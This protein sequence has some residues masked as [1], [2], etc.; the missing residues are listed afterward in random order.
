MLIFIVGCKFEYCFLLLLLTK[1]FIS[2]FKKFKAKDDYDNEDDEKDEDYDNDDDDDIVLMDIGNKTES[3][4]KHANNITDELDLNH[5]E[6]NNVIKSN[7]ESYDTDLGNQDH[8]RYTLNSNV[9]RMK[10]ARQKVA[11]EPFP[12]DVV[13]DRNKIDTIALARVMI[14]ELGRYKIPRSAFADHILHCSQ[15]TLTRALKDPRPWRE[16]T[17]ANFDSTKALYVQIKKWLQKPLIERR[18]EY[19]A[20]K[21]LLLENGSESNDITSA[22]KRS[23][24]SSNRDS[25]DSNFTATTYTPFVVI[26]QKCWRGYRIRSRL[27]RETPSFRIIR[28]RLRFIDQY[29]MRQY[30]NNGGDPDI[31]RQFLQ[32]SR[33]IEQMV[34]RDTC[35][36]TFESIQRKMQQVQKLSMKIFEILN[37]HEQNERN[38]Q[39]AKIKI[40]HEQQLQNIQEEYRKQIEQLQKQLKES[41][42]QQIQ[43]VQH[44]HQSNYLEAQSTTTIQQPTQFYQINY[45]PYRY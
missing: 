41:Q 11:I 45:E 37:Q 30:Q 13:F 10:K 17:K 16:M 19:I 26:I 24:D 39:L 22:N 3:T 23:I 27:D 5:I 12:H 21:A 4:T 6:Q 1:K 32:I 15:Y 18:R 20:V 36:E 33:T 43:I 44:G 38:R 35:K 42:E 8:L 14:A 28:Q 7:Q 31:N 9:V 40:D 2:I 25:N 29:R 34:R